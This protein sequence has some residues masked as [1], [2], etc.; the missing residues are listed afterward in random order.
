MENERLENIKGHLGLGDNNQNNKD[1]FVR[2]NR[3]NINGDSVSGSI[4]VE[5]IRVF[6]SNDKGINSKFIKLKLIL[7]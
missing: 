6:K 3:V 7:I 4:H 5:K 2:F 1:G